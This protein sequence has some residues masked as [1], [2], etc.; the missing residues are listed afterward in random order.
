ML[1]EMATSGCGNRPRGSEQLLKRTESAKQA[2]P[3]RAGEAA[4]HGE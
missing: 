2:A 1:G 4:N 3:A